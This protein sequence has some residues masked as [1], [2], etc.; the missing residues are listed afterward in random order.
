MQLDITLANLICAPV[1]ETLVDDFLAA[2]ED[3]ALIA[4]AVELRVDYLTWYEPVRVIE[5]L[6]V[7]KNKIQKPLILTYRPS[8]QGG[9]KDLK[10]NDRIAFWR[11]FDS[12]DV[13]TYADLEWD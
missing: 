5:F 2:V 3:A 10:F 4:D 11:G 1:T 8:E 6:S 7:Q 13:I 9:Q 12:W